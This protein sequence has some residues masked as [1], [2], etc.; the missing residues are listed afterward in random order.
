VSNHHPFDARKELEAFL[1]DNADLEALEAMI[2]EFNIF[3]AIGVI[4]Q[5]VKH[6]QFLA[7]LLN[8]NGNHGLDD[9][10]LKRLLMAALRGVDGSLIT[11]LDLDLMEL[12]SAEVQ[13]EWS[14]IDILITDP[15]NRFACIIENKVF[16]S[17]HDEQLQ[18]YQTIVQLQ[19]P[20]WQIIGLYLTPD[21][22]P[23]SDETY[24]PISYVQVAEVLEELLKA[25]AS[26]MGS[27]IRTLIA[28]YITM[29]RRHIVTESE[30]ADLC[31][32]I[33]TR[34]QRAGLD[35]LTSS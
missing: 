17:E 16:T 28:H 14:N 21:G 33:Y 8:P 3:E 19:Y 32:R 27:D 7:L 18:R 12:S 22:S 2:A 31:R 20:G 24:I 34:H 6:S 10:F 5:E 13:R 26:V 1:I 23:P 35:L 25:R 15:V 4:Y 30:I 11:P 9:L 29:L